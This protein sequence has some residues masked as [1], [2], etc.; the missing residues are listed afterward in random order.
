VL[1]SSGEWT[2]KEGTGNPGSAGPDTFPA[3][4]ISTPLYSGSADLTKARGYVL[5]SCSGGS[6]LE[7]SIVTP[8]GPSN[9]LYTRVCASTV[10]GSGTS[11]LDPGLIVEIEEK[12]GGPI[13]EDVSI[14][15]PQPGQTCAGPYT[16]WTFSPKASFSF[17]IDNRTLP[18][19]EK[20]DKV[21]H[22]DDGNGTFDTVTGDCTIKIVNSQKI[23][24]VTC[25]AS[26]NG[27]WR[28]G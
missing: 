10:P 12:A 14:C 27:S 6:S 17:T 7:T 1:E 20:V 18:P 22:D 3:G 9:K 19:G 25:S 13:T 28:F 11:P 5:R 21:F 2:I 4:T 26:Q 16:P 24:N 15:I 23:T 8:V